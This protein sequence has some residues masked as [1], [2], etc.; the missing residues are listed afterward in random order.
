L[1]DKKTLLSVVEAASWRH[2]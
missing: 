2:L 1:P